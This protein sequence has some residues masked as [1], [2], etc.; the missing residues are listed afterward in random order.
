VSPPSSVVDPEST[1]TSTSMYTGAKRALMVRAA[2]T[3]L[4]AVAGLVAARVTVSSLGVNGYA[5]FALVVG[6]AAL[7]PIGDLGVGGAVTDA[8]ARRDEMGPDGVQRVLRTS[9]RVLVVVSFLVT[10]GS[11]ALA[12]LG[13]WAPVLGVPASGEL[14]VAVAA[15][16]TLFAAGLP[17]GLSLSVLLGAER[18]DIAVAFQG[19][20]SL[21]ALLIVLLAAETHAPLWAY[22]AAS[23]TGAAIAVTAAWPMASK[24]SG[25]P[26]LSIVRSA[27][28]RARA[29]ARIAHFAGPMMVIMMSLPIAYQ[30]DRLLLSHLSDLGQV[31]IYSIGTQLYSP[32][33]GLIGAAGMS[34]WPM[35]AR[36]RAHHPVARREL[37]KLVA[38]FAFVGLLLALALVIAGPWVAQF[39]SK[40]KIDVSRGVFVAFGILLVVQACWLPIGMHLTDRDGLRFQAVL[41]VVMLVVNLAVSAVLAHQMGAPGPL[42]GSAGA[43]VVTMW[44]PGAWRVLSQAPK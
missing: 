36:R 15:S 26:L 37:I 27:A 29:G 6:L 24:A 2:T 42:L 19:S 18:N 25:L 16:L 20:S 21:L 35:F 9:V 32:M 34:L 10:I 8:V 1:S 3:P 4:T 40:G 12:G 28:V 43:I 5:L 13:V 38:I 17:L 7:N 23:A 33:F 41:H 14:E 30:S 31:A 44:I 22:T 11:W 39:V